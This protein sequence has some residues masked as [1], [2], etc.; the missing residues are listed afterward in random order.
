MPKSIEPL[1][2]TG[3]LTDGADINVQVVYCITSPPEPTVH[4]FKGYVRPIDEDYDLAK[5]VG[6]HLTLMMQ[7]GGTLSLA[8]DD[9]HG[10]FKSKG[11]I[12]KR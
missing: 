1:T 12:V 6:I 5:L 9:A 4:K 3:S 11:P 2:G 7:D 10:N 8:L